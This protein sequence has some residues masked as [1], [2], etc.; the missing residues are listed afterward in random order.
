LEESQAREEFIG[1][2]LEHRISGLGDPD[3][4][5]P[6]I[7]GSMLIPS[8]VYLFR[9][10]N[11]AASILNEG[12]FDRNGRILLK[13]TDPIAIVSRELL[14]Q[15]GRPID[16]VIAAAESRVAAGEEEARER[17]LQRAKRALLDGNMVAVGDVIVEDPEL[18][19]SLDPDAIERTFREAKLAPSVRAAMR[20]PRGSRRRELLRAGRRLTEGHL[21]AAEEFIEKQKFATLSLQFMREDPRFRERLKKQRR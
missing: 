20:A 8:G 13:D 11:S 18:I 6:D 2:A 3:K 12:H 5:F 14:R 19:L 7:P 21:T 1:G 10:L 4:P 16:E 9:G 17:R 15:Y